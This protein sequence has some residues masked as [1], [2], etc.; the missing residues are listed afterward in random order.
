MQL[1]SLPFNV[2]AF[3]VLNDAVVII[4]DLSNV[5]YVNDSAV[6]FYRVPKGLAV[7]GKLENL[8]NQEWL[9]GVEQIALSQL[10]EKGYWSGKTVHVSKNGEKLSVHLSLSAFKDSNGKSLG[11]V[12]IVSK[13][14]SSETAADV[15]GADGK[16]L[17]ESFFDSRIDIDR[18]ALANIIDIKALQSMMDDLYSVTKIGFAVIDLKA[19]VLA[20]TGWQDICTQFHRVNPKSLWN[21]LESDLVLTQNVKQGQFQ[22]YKCK[23]QMWDIVTPL[24]IGKKHVGNLFSGQFFFDD[25]TV[26]RELFA[27]QADQFGFDKEAYLTAL[28]NVPRWNRAVVNNLMRFYVKLAEMLSKLG[29]SNLRLS[30]LLSDQKKVEAQLRESHHDLN[31]AQGVSKTGSWRLNLQSKV[32]LWS[33]ETYRMFGVPRGTPMT[34]EHFLEY[35]HPE[36][37]RMVDEHWKAALRGDPYD[38]E[39]R[40]RVDGKVFWVHEKAELEFGEDGSLISG[41]GTVQDI[42]EHK[43]DQDRLL[44]LNRALRAIS[45]S[46]QVLMRATDEAAFLQQACRIIVEDCGY[47]LVW[48]GFAQENDDKTVKPMAYAGFDR[49]YIDSLQITWADNER[50]QGPSGRAIRTGKSQICKDITSDPCFA[51]WRKNALERGYRSSIV[52]PLLSEGKAFGVLNIYSSELNHFTTDE[53][54]LLSELASDFSHGIMLLRMRCAAKVAEEALRKSEAIARNRA[55]ELETLHQKLEEKAAEVEEYA[56]NMENL[57]QERLRQLQDA[58]RLIAIGSTAGMVGHDIRNPL[59][60]LNLDIYFAFSEVKALPDSAQKEQLKQSLDA[61]QSSTDYINRIVQDLQ[62]YA[63][64][65]KLTLREAS[66]FSVCKESLLGSKVPPH[67]STSCQMDES[68]KI[69]TDSVVLKRILTNLVI[70][71]VQA[72]PNKGHISMQA[73]KEKDDIIITV[74]DDGIGISEDIKPKLFTPLMTTKTSGTGFGL[75]V[76]KRMTEALG[77]TVMFESQVGKG[78]TFIIRLP[79]SPRINE[80][81]HYK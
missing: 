52:L 24:I 80:E 13:D 71:A 1:G 45:D 64:P 46:N 53:I 35:I 34:Y 12:F 28:D 7:E 58:E 26:D 44:K 68:F 66:V 56:T 77:G 38:I 60:S 70:N 20:A 5:I 61:I 43:L 79:S 42:T 48:I 27:K 29:Y 8:F 4:D 6:R 65:L 11:T 21:C 72:I 74:T 33:D 54:K 76:V 78:S 37:R 47:Q 57:A 30:K 49:G 62:D 41:F 23:N 75:A 10:K 69:V 22:T 19:N 32:L 55:E 31:H 50:G 39:H 63:R 40:I 67:I 81:F 2:S 18:E 59:Q 9:S 16:L 3:D 73:H 17:W 51:P 25:E 14:P 15:D 36:D